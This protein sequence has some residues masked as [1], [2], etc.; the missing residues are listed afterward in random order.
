M[1]M[2]VSKKIT[3]L[4]VFV[5]ACFYSGA[6]KTADPVVVL[7]KQYQ[8]AATITGKVTDAST[9]KGLRGIRVTYKAY[10][11]AIT[12]SIGTF[13]LKVPSMDVAVLLEGDGYQ[14][15]EIALRGHS[16]INAALYEDTYTSFYDQSVEPFGSVMKNKTTFAG[17]SVQTNGN[18]GRI[19]ETPSSYLQGKVAG[20]NVI[21]RSGTPN[22]G[23]SLTLRGISSLYGT[24]QPLIVVDGILFNNQDLGGSIITN[25]YTDPLSTIDVRDIDNITVLKDGSSIYGTKGSNGVII[26][27]T[28]RAKELGTKID[29]STFGGINLTPSNIPVLNSS[30]YRIYLSEI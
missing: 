24:N 17:S 18:W 30:D 8:G 3:A 29:F 25:H 10:S 13:T 26:I 9:G 14:S 5:F 21:R 12:D 1:I 27:T 4:T 7:Q 11:A 15:K 19:T 16:S 2:Q 20:L 23:G 6:Q 28:A 22:I